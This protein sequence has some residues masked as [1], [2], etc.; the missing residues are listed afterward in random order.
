MVRDTT[1]IP[2]IYPYQFHVP[3]VNRNVL[4]SKGYPYWDLRWKIIQLPKERDTVNFKI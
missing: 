1:L 4:D 2:D 3:S